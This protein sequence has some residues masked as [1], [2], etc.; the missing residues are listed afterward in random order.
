MI[1]VGKENFYIFIVIDVRVFFQDR[2][3]VATHNPQ[4]S[5]TFQQ[6]YV[7][8]FSVEAR[9][10]IEIFKNSIGRREQRVVYF[11]P[12]VREASVYVFVDGDIFFCVP[13]KG[14]SRSHNVARFDD[15]WGAYLE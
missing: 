1:H 8:R 5:Q 7:R 13:E 4:I 3:H 10:F 6:F 2:V 9:F 12:R 15:R 11:F 14:M